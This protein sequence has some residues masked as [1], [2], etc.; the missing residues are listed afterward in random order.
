[1]PRTAP[2]ELYH[3]RYDDWFVQHAAAYHSELLAV[4]A[5][6]PWDGLGLSIGV[7]T[8]RFAAPLGVQAG[9]DPAHEVLGYAAQRGVAVAQGVAEALPFADQVF[10]YALI[11]TT[12]CFVDDAGAMLNEAYRVV[13]S[14]GELVIGFIDR[15]SELGQY[16]LAHQNEN[17]FYRDAT[18]YTATEVQQLLHEAGF[19]KPV[20]VQTLSKMLDETCEIEPVH[21][22]Y[23]EAAFVVVRASRP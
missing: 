1:M 10:D 14:G 19:V 5:L 11:V 12:I 22:G 21:S 23:G 9:I 15:D 7:G 6:L 2:F 16:Y 4:R 13:R 3:Q 17:V 20:W 8:G 18:F